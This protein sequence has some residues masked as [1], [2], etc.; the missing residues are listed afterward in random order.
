MH[1]NLRLNLLPHTAVLI[2]LATGLCYATDEPT[3]RVSLQPAN[4]RRLAP[5]FVLKDSGGKTLTLEQYLGKVVLLDFW[6]TWCHGCKEEIPWFSDFQHR[7][8]SK[9]LQVIG[10]STDDEGWKVVQPF[11]AKADIPYP[12]IL[13]NVAMQKNYHIENMPDAFLI[14]RV[15]RIAAVYVGLVDKE[16][17]EGNIKAMLGER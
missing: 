4:Q 11:L 3:V 2:F 1:R 8:G 10:A 7:Y 17:V 13:S 14:D 6:A 16:N 9:G 12:I 5:A 15:G